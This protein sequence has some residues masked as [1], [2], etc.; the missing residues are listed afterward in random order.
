MF[1]KIAVPAIAVLV[2]LAGSPALGSASGAAYASD[3][4]FVTDDSESL[5]VE[6]PSEWSEVD[7]TPMEDDDGNLIGPRLMA[8]PDLAGFAEDYA[9][10]GV[11][12]LA[13]EPADVDEMLD[14]FAPAGCTSQGRN[15]YDD[16]IYVGQIELFSDCDGAPGA[17]V[18]LV[19]AQPE[20]GDF[21]VLV[22]VQ[23]VTAADQQAYE[24]ISERFWSCKTPKSKPAVG[25]TVASD[26][27][28]PSSRGGATGR[29]S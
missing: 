23:M 4:V 15:D 6:I 28:W 2:S 14:E 27:P 29:F 11:A 17:V 22:D 7:G 3:Y 25:Q 9:T 8:S 18:G 19:A 1:R 10:P 20:S 21:N 26:L 5:Q 16:G 24:K 12:F 13:T